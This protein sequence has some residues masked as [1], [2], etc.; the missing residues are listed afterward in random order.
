MFLCCTNA[1]SLVFTAAVC[2]LRHLVLSSLAMQT[3]VLLVP[4][5]Q[6]IVKYIMNST[7]C[8]VKT[9]TFSVDTEKAQSVQ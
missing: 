8:K 9:N 4:I 2:V 7:I 1:G 3:R 5:S 6:P